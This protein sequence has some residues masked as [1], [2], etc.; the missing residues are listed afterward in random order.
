MPRFGYLLVAENVIQDAISRKLTLVDVFENINIQPGSD[1]VY[2]S[3]FVVGRIL[4]VPP[5]EA[6]VKLQITGPNGFS[7]E[8]TGS[9]TLQPGSLDVYLK[10]NLLKFTNPGVY[11]L[12]AFIN[13]EEI[14]SPCDFVFRVNKSV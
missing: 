10:F 11:N 2:S 1:S 3:F 7:A 8:Q 5:G 12:K 13:E 6:V 4:D 9:S 14:I